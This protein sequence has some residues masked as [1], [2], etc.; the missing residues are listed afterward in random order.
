MPDL[1]LYFLQASRSIRTAWILEELKLD[2]KLEF[3]E[4]ENGMASQAFKKKSG[5]AM[6]KFPLLTD[7]ELT[8]GESGA[9]AEYVNPIYLFSPTRIVPNHVVSPQISLR[10]VRHGPPTDPLGSRTE[11]G[12]HP[13]D[14]HGRGHLHAPRARD[15][16]HRVVRRRQ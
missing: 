12:V 4:R 9:Q 2:Y 5:D 13:L 8:I 16:V 6:G 3:A 7:G 10:K 1:T 14:T 11:V 15:P